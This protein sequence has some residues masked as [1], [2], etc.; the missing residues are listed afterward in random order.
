MQSTNRRQNEELSGLRGKEP[1]II[2]ELES[3]LQIARADQKKSNQYA[4]E[5]ENKLVELE[6]ELKDAGRAERVELSSTISW[7]AASCQLAT[8]I[9]L[10]L[11]IVQMHWGYLSNMS[12]DLH[13]NSGIVHKGFSYP[14]CLGSM[15]NFICGVTWH[16]EKWLENCPKTS[17][18]LSGKLD[19]AQEIQVTK[20]ISILVTDKRIVSSYRIEKGNT[21]KRDTNIKKP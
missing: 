2:A 16:F 11:W 12:L 10:C 6:R 13:L 7:S 9:F 15:L 4:G 5:C 8:Q 1:S 20:L 17:C 19:A 3:K 18:T 14:F 21:R